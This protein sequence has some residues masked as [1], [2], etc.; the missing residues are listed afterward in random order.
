MFLG[1]EIGGTKLQLGVGPGDGT[2]VALERTRVDPAPGAEGI[3]RQIIELVPKILA[4]AGLARSDIRAVGIGFGG[5]VDAERGIVTK[6]H[7]IEGWAGFPLADW[8]RETLGWPTVVHNDADTAGLAEACFGAGRGLSPIFYITIGSGIG[9]GLIINQEIYR[10]AGA[11]AAEIGHLLLPKPADLLEAEVT[12]QRHS[13]VTFPNTVES[14][15][16]GWAME[17][18]MQKTLEVV[19]ALA[20]EQKKRLLP[21]KVWTEELLDAES[22]LAKADYFPNQVDFVIIANAARDGHKMGQR[23]LATSVR[24]LG[25]AIGQM[26]TLL[27]PRRIVIGGGVA[28]IGE[29]LLLQPLRREVARYVFPPFI[30]CYDIAPAAL[31]EAVVIHGALRLARHFVTPPSK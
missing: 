7:Q 15:C 6:S 14:V 31:G 12:W 18:R 4:A 26:I 25:W 11:G 24:I 30:D 13:P 21:T 22:L 10:G 27:C 17:R 3:R 19:T 1:I 20:D 9:G 5:P 29:E 23:F 2:I 28:S 16:S 8:S